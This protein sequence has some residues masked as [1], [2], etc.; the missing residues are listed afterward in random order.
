MCV[1]T[2]HVLHAIQYYM[3]IIRICAMYIYNY[4]YVLS[5]TC[6]HICTVYGSLSQ[7][8]FDPVQHAT[9]NTPGVLNQAPDVNQHANSNKKRKGKKHLK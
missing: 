4:M 5:M 7:H 1:D 2:A 9:Y 6:M 3:Y 8:I